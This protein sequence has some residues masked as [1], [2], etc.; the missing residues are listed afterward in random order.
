VQGYRRP[1][2]VVAEFRDASGVAIPYGRR[3]P[4]LPPE[5][6]YSVTAHPERFAPIVDVASELVSSLAR[7]YQVTRVE[8]GAEAFENSDGIVAASR[9]SPEGGGAPITVAQTAFPGVRVKVGRTAE[10]SFPSCGCDACDEDVEQQI[11][12]LEQLLDAV[13]AGR[14]LEAEAELGAGEPVPVLYE[15]SG[16]W[17]TVGGGRQLDVAGPSRWAAWA[18]WAPRARNWD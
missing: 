15:Y 17:G 3:W 8:G 5:S 10:F 11:E 18:A 7:S 16:D 1:P 13:V 2:V 6:A 9:L 4:E 14:F 12:R